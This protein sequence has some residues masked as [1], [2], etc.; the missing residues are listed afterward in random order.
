MAIEIRI[1]QLA[2]EEAIKD[3]CFV[4]SAWGRDDKEELRDLIALR[5]CL[6]YLRYERMHC[7]VAV[8]TEKEFAVVGYL[9]CAPSTKQYEIEYREKTLP[10]IDA[11]IKRLQPKP[12][13]AQMNLKKDFLL[14]SKIK[15]GAK[16]KKV[17]EEYPAHI[18]IDIY[19]SYHRRGIGRMLFAAHEEHL[20]EI[21]CEG[22]HLTV[23]TSNEAAVRFYRAMGMEDTAHIGGKLNFGIAFAK[24]V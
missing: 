12:G 16:V 1:L 10:M 4:T 21:G 11:E 18:H 24:R 20:R 23:G 7:H 3:I 9:L 6:H 8:D 15:L 2:D 14:S 19:P 17:I 13:L 5:W 22:Y